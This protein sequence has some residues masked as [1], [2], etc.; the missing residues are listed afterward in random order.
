MDD[1]TRN[2][3]DPFIQHDSYLD[4][5]KN[6]YMESTSYLD[7]NYRKQLDDNIKMFQNKHPSGSKYNKDSYKYRS[8]LFRPKTRSGERKT[9]AAAA[10]AFFNNSDVVEIEPQTDNDE[11]QQASADLYKELLNYRL[12]SKPIRWFLTCLGAIQDA[13]VA[14]VVCSYNYWKYSEKRTTRTETRPAID[15]SGQPIIDF[16]TGEP[17]YQDIEIEDVEV[18]EDHPCIDLIPL[19]NVRF[20]P[21]ANWIDPINSSPYL[22]RLIP[23]YV[24]EV[25]EKMAEIDKKTGQPKWRKLTDGQ[26]AQGRQKQG[27]ST[28]QAR[29][30]GRQDPNQEVSAISDYD[31]VWVHEN[32]IREKGKDIVYYTIA[33]NYLLT[34]PKPLKDVY[35]HGIRPVTMGYVVFE[36]HKAIPAS[37]VE[38]GAPLQREANEIANERRDNVKLVMNKRYIVKRGAQ[39]D[40]RSIVR[41]VSGSVTFAS[42]PDSDVKTIDHNDVTSSSYAEEDRINVDYDELIGNFSQGSVQTNRKL[43]E[44]VGGMN[45]LYSG[46][47]QMTEYGLRIFV[48]TWMEPTL[49]Q[50][51]KLEQAY[52]TDEVV[53]AIAA[54]KAQ[55]AQKY[56]IS[57]EIDSLLEQE[58]TLRVNVGLGASNPMFR[59]ERLVYAIKTFVDIAQAA[60]PSAKLD[61]IAKELFGAIG[62]RDGAKFLDFEQQED[63]KMQELMAAI[64]EMQKVIDQKQIEQEGKLAVEDMKK[65]VAEM[66]EENENARNDA[67]LDMQYFIEQLRQ[68]GKSDRPAA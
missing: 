49:R 63:P 17:V 5:A 55:L 33:T 36:T 10:A 27:T 56:G 57:E 41:N 64:E 22:I 26:I 46:A 4:K 42:N 30:G 65:A 68:E 51:V 20:H 61:E 31:I 6:A 39:V 58:L 2:T 48:E 25:K 28:Q 47:N 18:M 29:S 9:E 7:N 16:E 19:E 8:K 1:Q 15:E 21:A 54:D 59:L 45:L 24:F 53:L 62:Y 43:N 12:D 40:T 52:E 67:K 23:M 44:T 32:I 35:F 38:L 66:K 37:P 60:P 11:S 34:T 3:E 13:Y 14:G 50:L